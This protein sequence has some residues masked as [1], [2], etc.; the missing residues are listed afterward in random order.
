MIHHQASRPGLKE[1]KISS[2]STTGSGKEVFAATACPKC[3]YSSLFNPLLAH[4]DI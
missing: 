4:I 1:S 3:R 2:S